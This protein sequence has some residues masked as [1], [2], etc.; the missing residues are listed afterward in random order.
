MNYGQSDVGVLKTVVLKHARDAFVDDRFTAHQW[1][2]LNY[3]AKPDFARAV[4]EYDRLVALLFDLGV[5]P[6]F[7]PQDEATGLDSIYVRDA[8]VVC[9]AGVILCNMGKQAR[10]AEPDA[11]EGALRQAGVRIHGRIGQGGTL[12]GGDVVWLD[13]RTLAV[14]RGY[15]TSDTGIGQL[16][17]LLGDMIDELIV[18]PLPHWRGPDDVFH[19]MSILS[20]IDTN[21]MLVYSPLLPVP[22]REQLVSRGMTLVDVPDEEFATMGCNVLTVAPRRC[23]M[24]SGNPMTTRLLERAGAEVHLFDGAEICAKGAGGPTCLTRPIVRGPV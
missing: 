3:T 5:E 24:L 13:G 1:R 18:V 15:R 4:D 21:L 12:E 9:S 23:V 19:L 10:H 16:R 17:A 11:Q 14:G 22:F 20:P 8:S 6:V 2:G 7:L